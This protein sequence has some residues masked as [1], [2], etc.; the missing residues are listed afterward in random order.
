MTREKLEAT[1]D[2]SSEHDI[3]EGTLTVFFEESGERVLHDSG[4]STWDVDVKIIGAVYALY[5]GGEEVLTEDQ[6]A[7]RFGKWVVKSIIE[8]QIEELN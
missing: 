7:E 5:E 8:E 6:I 4:R 2:S 3:D 1:C